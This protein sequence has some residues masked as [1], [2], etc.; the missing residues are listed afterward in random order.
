MVDMVGMVGLV[1]LVGMVGMVG[2]VGMVG[3]VGWVDCNA[4]LESMV[5]HAQQIKNR[6]PKQTTKP[7]TNTTALPDL[8]SIGLSMTV[9]ITTTNI[10]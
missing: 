10:V 7:T 4:L 2:F 3:M 1:G 6:T 8:K 5:Q 9:F